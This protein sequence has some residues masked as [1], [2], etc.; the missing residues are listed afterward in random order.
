MEGWVSALAAF[1]TRNCGAATGV[2]A[3]RTPLMS[4]AM[5]TEP[6]YSRFT[7]TLPLWSLAT[8]YSKYAVLDTIG[9][10]IGSV[11]MRWATSW[12]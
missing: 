5:S 10:G 12:P 2:G 1:E 11:T 6:L 8:W 9:I 4:E 7:A 3:M